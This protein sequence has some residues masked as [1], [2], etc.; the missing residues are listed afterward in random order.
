ML[1]NNISVRDKLK[2]Q[3]IITDTQILPK[4][5]LFSKKGHEKFVLIYGESSIPGYQ[6]YKLI[7]EIIYLEIPELK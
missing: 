6:I 4:F 5:V 1:E 3:R 7:H 2:V